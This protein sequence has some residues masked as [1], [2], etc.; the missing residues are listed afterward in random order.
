M[1]IEILALNEMPDGSLNAEVNYDDEA[2][3]HIKAACGVTEIAPEV[4]SKFV[5]G[6]LRSYVEEDTEA[7]HP[8]R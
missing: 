8:N 6:A 1:K 2:A 3:E 4:L 7:K 5:A